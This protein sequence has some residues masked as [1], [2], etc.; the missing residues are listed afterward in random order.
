MKLTHRH[1]D[2][3]FARFMSSLPRAQQTQIRHLISD[4]GLEVL[5]GPKQQS[6]KL[7]NKKAQ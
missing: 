5:V 4:L 7:K 2:R 3:Q 6:T 1:E